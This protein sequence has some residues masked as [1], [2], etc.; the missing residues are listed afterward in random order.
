MTLS[1][2]KALNG[3]EKC[4]NSDSKILPSSIHDNHQGRERLNRSCEVCCQVNE[5]ACGS[6]I[7]N[8]AEI[9]QLSLAFDNCRKLPAPGAG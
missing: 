3:A 9:E 7:S 5:M 8:Y 4:G 6:A 1:E 2:M